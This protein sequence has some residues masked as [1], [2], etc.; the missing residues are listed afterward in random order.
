MKMKTITATL[1]LILGLAIGGFAGNY[2]GKAQVLERM[3]MQTTDA[4]GNI[5]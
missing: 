1:A 4:M 2:Y 3:V 5:N